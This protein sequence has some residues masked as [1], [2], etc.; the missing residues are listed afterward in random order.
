[1][2]ILGV[3][4]GEA[5]VGLAWSDDARRLALPLATV[6]GAGGHDAV[7]ERVEAALGA[8]RPGEIVVGLPLTLEGAEGASARRAR[9]FAAALA[10]RFD[11]PVELWDERLTTVAAERSLRAANVRGRAQRH[12]VDQSAAALLLQSYLDAKAEGTWDDAQI[13]AMM[14]SPG[15]SPRRPR[16]PRPARAGGGAGSRKGRGGGRGSER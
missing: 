9:A 3:D 12:L 6:P 14:Q 13:E 10:A 15:P 1:M 5:R 2:R 11:C 16:R 8:E 4:P 7:A